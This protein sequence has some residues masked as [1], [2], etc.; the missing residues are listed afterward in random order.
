ME[1]IIKIKAMQQIKVETLLREN[2]FSK[3]AITKLKQTEDGITLNNKLVFTTYI[4]NESEEITVK[5]IDDKSSENI[6]E[7]KL[8]F[9]IVYEDD[10]ILVINKPSNMPIHPS[11]NNFSN[12]LANGLAYYY[13][14][15]NFVYRVINRLDR[16]TTGLLIVAK[17]KLSASILSDMIKKREI[18]RKYIAICKGMLES[19]GT[20]SANIQRKEASTIEREVTENGGDIAITNYKL[21]DYK[22]GHSLVLLKLE[23]GRT[24]QIRVH[25]KHNKTPIIGDFLY[26][27]DY[28]FIDRQAL[29]SVSLS[30]NHPVTGKSLNFVSNLPKDM[31]IF[32]FTFQRNML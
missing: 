30:F 18:K 7:T 9:E 19:S 32:G 28:E 15:E 21:L 26:N 17:N 4:L 23:T 29:H 31:Q 24:H 1:R 11:I 8:D 13:R 12:T 14:K 25:M 2:G 16:D 20:I 10:D 22:N 6:V 27:P 3:K 5:C